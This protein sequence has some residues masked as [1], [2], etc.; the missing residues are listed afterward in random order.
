[1]T[2][3]NVHP[4]KVSSSI[5][6]HIFAEFCNHHHHPISEYFHHPKKDT[7]YPLAATFYFLPSLV[8]QPIT[9]LGSVSFLKKTLV[10]L[11]TKSLELKLFY[12]YLHAIFPL[13]YRS[14]GRMLFHSELWWYYSVFWPLLLF[15][16]S[17][18]SI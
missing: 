12:K 16:E 4:F 17:R 18:M 7:P 5:V 9:S 6:F 11:S 2:Y 13:E 1:M 15:L 8:W 14:I 3:H 10:V